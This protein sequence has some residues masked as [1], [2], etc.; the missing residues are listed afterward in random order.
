MPK[1]TQNH[2]LFTKGALE[3][4]NFLLKYR[5][6]PSYMMMGTVPP[7]AFKLG[8]WDVGMESY[9][10]TN[11]E[12]PTPKYVEMRERERTWNTTVVFSSICLKWQDSSAGCH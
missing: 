8:V 4:T 7:N 6:T 9:H 12:I 2:I 10:L 3:Q 5:D 1:C 11:F